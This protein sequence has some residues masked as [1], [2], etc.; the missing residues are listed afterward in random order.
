M[1]LVKLPD[2]GWVNPEMVVRISQG[3]GQ[4]NA[5]WI[6]IHLIDEDSVTIKGGYTIDQVASI[7][8]DTDFKVIED[9]LVVNK[10]QVAAVRVLVEDGDDHDP[11]VT[12]VL[13]LANGGILE[14]DSDIDEVLGQLD[15]I[16]FFR[17]ADDG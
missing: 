14:T 8:I 12:T 3:T 1:R 13:Q 16:P 7:F 5:D 15:G 6:T 9:D 11:V 17:E 10:N 2:N 4:I